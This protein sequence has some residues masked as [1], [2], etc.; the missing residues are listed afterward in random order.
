MSADQP[1]DTIDEKSELTPEAL[2]VINRA[3]R[4]FGISI[5]ILLIGFMAVAGALVYRLNQKSSDDRYQAQSVSLPQGATIVSVVAQ[6]GLITLTYK[7]GATTT[8]RVVNATSGEVV[9][10]ISVVAEVPAN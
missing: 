1:S 6:N 8:I 5:F 2:A 7:L 9:R 3:R 4:S 10:D